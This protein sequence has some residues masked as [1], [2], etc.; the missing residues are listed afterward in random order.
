MLKGD[1][2]G[3]DPAWPCG[4]LDLLLKHRETL[5]IKIDAADADGRTA[6][7]QA[8][9]DQAD[10]PDPNSVNGSEVESEM[11][12]MPSSNMTTLVGDA[13]NAGRHTA[14]QQAAQSESRIGAVIER[15]LQAGATAN[16]RDLGGS[17]PLHCAAAAGNARGVEVLLQVR[18][19][20]ASVWSRTRCLAL[21]WPAGRA[22]WGRCDG[23][24]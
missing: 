21:T 13:S 16:V 19:E 4:V 18:R 9:M 8:C 5:S 6:L 22:G 3:D 10:D 23:A 20:M 1:R 12:G 17:T 24:R 2:A 11:D 14:E 15:L 7:H